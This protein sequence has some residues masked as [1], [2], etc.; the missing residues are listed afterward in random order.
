MSGAD[1]MP[2]PPNVERAAYELSTD[3]ARVTAT[4][5]FTQVAMDTAAGTVPGWAGQSADAYNA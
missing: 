4:I 3:L 5:N 2:L 1:V